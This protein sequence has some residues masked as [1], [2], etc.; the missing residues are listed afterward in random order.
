MTRKSYWK[1]AAEPVEAAQRFLAP[2]V[3]FVG[4]GEDEPPAR[5]HV[6]KIVD[7]HGDVREVFAPPGHISR[8]P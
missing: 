7:E 4:R 8:W 5:P 1:K 6:F 2:L 3:A